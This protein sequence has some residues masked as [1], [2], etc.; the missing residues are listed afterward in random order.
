MTLGANHSRFSLGPPAEAAWR[1]AGSASATHF[2]STR[3]N[4]PASDAGVARLRPAF[5]RTWRSALSQAQP[6]WHG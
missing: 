6:N 5:A 1:S 2:R 3:L 4:A